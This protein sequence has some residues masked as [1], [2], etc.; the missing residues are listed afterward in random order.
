MRS[1]GGEMN[2]LPNLD[3]KAVVTQPFRVF[4]TC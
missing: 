4:R 1:R 2:P 3:D